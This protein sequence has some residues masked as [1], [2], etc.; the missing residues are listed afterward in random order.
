MKVVII[1]GSRRDGSLTRELTDMACEQVKGGDHDLTYIDLR[2]TKV[3][4]FRGF[5]AG[6]GEVTRGVI[7]KLESAD[8]FIIGSPVYNGLLSSGVKNL[9]EHVNYKGLEGAVAGF[10][11]K[12]GTAKGFLAVENQLA[13]LMSYFR[14]L[15][16]PRAVFAHDGDYED[17]KL[18]DGD[19]K[20]RVER[21]VD[22]TLGMARAK[23]V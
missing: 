6:Y 2:E 23:Q 19:I 1:C 4:A 13:A 21:L 20:E 9:F 15:V 7:D 16:N 3:E 5:G 8:A 18:A 11:V 12:G 17:G 14:V 22:S 10:M